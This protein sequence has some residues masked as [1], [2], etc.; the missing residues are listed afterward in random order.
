MPVF[1]NVSL[2]PPYGLLSGL[3]WQDSWT[4]KAHT[5]RLAAYGVPIDLYVLALLGLWNSTE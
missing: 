3:E 2:T 5:F 4:R 1:D